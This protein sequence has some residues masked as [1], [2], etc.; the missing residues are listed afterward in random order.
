VAPR[1]KMHARAP[2]NSDPRQAQILA[3][4]NRI[5]KTAQKNSYLDS[6]RNPLIPGAK[7]PDMFTLQPTCT[8]QTNAEFMVSGGLGSNSNNIVSVLFDP[9]N[10]SYTVALASSTPAAINW[11]TSYTTMPGYANINSFYTSWRVVSACL[12]YFYIGNDSGNAG[13]AVAAQIDKHQYG[14]ANGPSSYANWTAFPNKDMRP[15]KFAGRIIW[16]PTDNNDVELHNVSSEAPMIGFVATAL[17]D[18][19]NFQIRM[20]VN[21]EA[22]PKSET[23]NLLNPTPSPSNPGYMAAASRWLSATPFYIGVPTAITSGAVYAT[24]QVSAAYRD[25]DNFSE[26]RSM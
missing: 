18:N 6:I 12:D 25:F 7:V 17:S 19:A 16:R 3:P 20:V 21:Y 8:M 11:P 23:L 15:S 9:A 26:S 4:M 22:I 10:I 2:V 13:I 1:G 5:A 14:G 24:R